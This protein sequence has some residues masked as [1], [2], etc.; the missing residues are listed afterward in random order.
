VL[1][2]SGLLVEANDAALNAAGLE[3][4]KE[5]GRSFWHT[6]WWQD[7]PEVQESIHAAILGAMLGT[8]SRQESRFL[9][10]HSEERWTDLYITPIQ[11]DDRPVAILVE[12]RD[13]TDQRAARLAIEA[14]CAAAE[15][16]NK[17]KDELLAA[18][19]HEL[20][21]PL[22]PALLLADEGS[23]NEA[24]P[25]SV[26][27]DF[28]AIAKNIVLE[29]RLIED[30]LDLCRATRAKLS[31]SSKPI[32]ISAVLRDALKIVEADITAKHLTL[33]LQL[34]DG[35]PLVSGD[36]MRLQQVFWNVLK[37][38]VKFTPVGG[39]IRVGAAMDVERQLIT[40]A[41]EDNGIGMTSAELDRVFKAFAQGD[42]ATQGSPH[43]YGGLGLGLAISRTIVEMH[44]GHI[45]AASP[46]RG[47]GTVISIEL[48]CLVAN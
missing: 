1:D 36:A 11:E 43:S 25:S 30:I 38:A 2:P 23:E 13:I 26:R 39:C 48:P 24:L 3:R 33:N 46:G 31:M 32:S 35:D 21:T 40:I 16:A 6:G 41:V 22:G 27:A 12:G 44:L 7:A 37:N 14:A 5:L 10:Q 17:A 28:G 9:N 19:A 8:A 4:E 29:A 45:D 47:W 20:R 15:G 42:H 34:P 18:I